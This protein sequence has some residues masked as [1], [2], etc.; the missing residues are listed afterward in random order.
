M[1][2]SWLAD[3]TGGGVVFCTLNSSMARSITRYGVLLVSLRVLMF[4]RELD[5]HQ[6]RVKASRAIVCRAI[7][8]ARAGQ[9]PV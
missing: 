9:R 3:E 1:R 8:D 2:Q 4:W 6:R 7:L 5:P